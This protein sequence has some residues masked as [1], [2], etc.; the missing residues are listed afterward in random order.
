MTRASITNAMLRSLVWLGATA[1]L[2]WLKSADDGGV[3]AIQRNLIAWAGGALLLVG[4]ALH[5]WSNVSLARGDAVPPKLVVRGP[6]RF[7]R[8]P[9]YLAGFILLTGTCLLYANVKVADLV[10]AI[11]LLAFFH[12]RVVRSEEPQLRK[13]HGSLFDD[14]CQRV[15]RW[16]PRFSTR[17]T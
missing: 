3:F 6:Y 1:L 5:I 10:G 14:Y 8:N 12:W 9:I 15:P 13:L 11:V 7:V 2:A 4:L 16:I 17:Y